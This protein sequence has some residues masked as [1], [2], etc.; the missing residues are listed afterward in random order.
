MKFVTRSGNGLGPFIS[1]RIIEAHSAGYA[2][3]IMILME[4]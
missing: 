2:E 1:K 3:K 4:K